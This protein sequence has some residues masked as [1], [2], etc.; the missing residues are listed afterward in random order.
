MTLTMAASAQGE[1]EL[2]RQQIEQLKRRLAE[3]DAPD[4]ASEAEIEQ[5]VKERTADL[6]R[7][8]EYLQQF[9]YVASHDLQE[10]LRTIVGYSQL[11]ESRYKDQLD[12][13]GREFLQYV[14][15]AAQRMNT[16][17]RDLLSYS[18]VANAD[19]LSLQ[20]VDM[21]SVLAGVQLNLMKAI[22]EAGAV[23]TSDRLPAVL[24]DEA[25]LAQL[26]QNLITNAIKFRGA[27]PPHI[28][29]SAEDR[30]DFW[31][32]SISDNG[33]GI[34]PAYHERIFGLFK[35]LTG[36]E[37]PGSGLGLAI[38]RKIAEKH[39]GRI[40][41]ESEAGHGAVFYFTLCT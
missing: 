34:D 18:R 9:A 3:R 15:G 40:W 39:N 11:I 21:N 6:R 41:V 1:I 29:M 33:I 14:T 10:P 35:R 32:F 22:E 25:L 24:G 19:N 27:D 20:Q 31:M 30:G 26:F 36:P 17:V 12:A 16:L 37:V 4:A 23:I 38:C 2:L 28:H 13:D 8:V 7:S 5:R